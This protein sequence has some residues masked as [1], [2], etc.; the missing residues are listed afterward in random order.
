MNKTVHN[1]IIGITNLLL[2]SVI[3]FSIDFESKVVLLVLWSIGVINFLLFVLSFSKS[4][5][6][7]SVGL[8]ISLMT[9]LF[10]IC[11][12]DVLRLFPK[13][14]PRGILDNLSGEQSERSRANTP[15]EFFDY[16]PYVR[17]K[18]YSK[19]T[20]A[21][22]PGRGLE[23]TQFVYD[24]TTDRL[25]FKNED[26]V[27]DSKID[28]VAVGD[29]FTEGM[30]VKIDE[31]MASQLTRAG[32]A[33]YN[34]GVGGYAPIQ[35]AGAFERFGKKLLPK[36]L[37]VGYTSGTY[38]R[39]RY[40]FDGGKMIANP[41][42]TF[43]GIQRIASPLPN[44]ITQQSKHVAFATYLFVKRAWSLGSIPL[45]EVSD[46]KL[47]LTQLMKEYEQEILVGR[48][49]VGPEF[50][51]SR[52]FGSFLDALLNLQLNAKEVGA[53][54]VVIYF[55]HRGEIYARSVVSDIGADTFGQVESRIVAQFCSERGILYRDMSGALLD[56]MQEL[57]ALAHSN[58]PYLEIDGHPSKVGFKVMADD[59]LQSGL[60]QLH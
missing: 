43:A 29:S 57:P 13:T 7:L 58:L 47:I 44:E 35:I 24:W 49:E 28:I 17:F 51:N 54:M 14:L 11:A 42:T 34:M 45:K 26:R 41:Q 46:P 3:Y 31:T 21:G 39:E 32:L 4:L 59:L 19:I 1:L 10:F 38:E 15:V 33:T 53:K 12:I 20:S 27:L 2:L 18:P 5:R 25:G 16:S 22:N 56:Y 36:I 37:L 8:L 52:E 40:Y 55:P 60:L 9:V 23:N 48:R 50:S 6:R 30:G